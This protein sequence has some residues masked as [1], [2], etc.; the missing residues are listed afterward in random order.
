MNDFVYLENTY[1]LENYLVLA[2]GIH[3]K[4]VSPTTIYR[5]N[6]LLSLGA[7]RHKGKVHSYRE[8]FERI[9]MR[10]KERG[11]H[12]PVTHVHR[13]MASHTGS[14][15]LLILERTGAPTKVQVCERVT[16]TQPRSMARGAILILTHTVVILTILCVACGVPL[17]TSLDCAQDVHAVAPTFAARAAGADGHVPET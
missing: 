10:R 2:T 8:M 16:S 14:N 5:S 3:T 1:P 12:W 15:A 4:S 6:H 11:S 13:L 9:Q 7:D 17:V